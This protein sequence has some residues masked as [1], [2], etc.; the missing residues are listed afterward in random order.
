MDKVVFGEQNE[1]MLFV[2]TETERGDA[3]DGGVGLQ[4]NDLSISKKGLEWSVIFN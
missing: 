3:H 1:K 4:R 2:G